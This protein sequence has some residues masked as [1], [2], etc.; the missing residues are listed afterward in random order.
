MEQKKTGIFRSNAPINFLFHP[1]ILSLVITLIVIFL[2]PRFPTYTATVT[3][4][5]QAP[6]TGM[7]LYD[8]LDGNGY[9]DEIITSMYDNGQAAVTVTFQPSLFF[10][11]W[12]IPGI[13]SFASDRY[14]MT[15][16]CD[17]NGEKELYLF[18]IA[19]D[20]ILLTV[21][22]DLFSKAPLFTTRYIDTLGNGSEEPHLSI[23]PGSMEDLDQDGS[24]T[25]FSICC[26]PTSR[27]TG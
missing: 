19:G 22:D 10:Q 1:V 4:R 9:S 17:Q 24:D 12:D 27:A 23:V 25:T 14:V 20:S 21:I 16:D 18:T 8:D 3:D 6:R 11:E 15:G 5:K 13:F 26:R 2:L 7:M